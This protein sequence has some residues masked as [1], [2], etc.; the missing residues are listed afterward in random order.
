VQHHFGTR[1]ELLLSLI[2]RSVRE[3]GARL[4]DAA[5]EGES[6]LDRLQAF[7]DLV[8]NHCRDPR[9]RVSWEIILEFRRR[10]EAA[11][12]YAQRLVTFEHAIDDAW[13]RLLRETLGGAD[14]RIV[15]RIIF[16]TMR[17]LALDAHTNPNAGEATQ[18]RA[19]LVRLI[20]DDLTRRVTWPDGS[21]RG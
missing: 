3:L 1:D 14:D 11:A 9:Y 5:V 12:A 15:R 19:Y 20:A 6:R 13:G 4:E 21:A 17:G 7:A 10:P 8:W 2:E 18:E 16:A